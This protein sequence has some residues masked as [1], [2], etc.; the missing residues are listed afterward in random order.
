MTELLKKITKADMR[1]ILAFIVTMGF[2]IQIL[3]ILNHGVP[4]SNKEVVYTSLGTS[5]AAFTLML[6]YYFGQSKSESDKNKTT[7]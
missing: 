2:F 4:E 6:S 1:H 3:I 7:E 5:G